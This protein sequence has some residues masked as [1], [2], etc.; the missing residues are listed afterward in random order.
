MNNDSHVKFLTFQ[1]P[2]KSHRS[3]SPVLYFNSNVKQ[4]PCWGKKK[5][6]NL[7]GYA[8]WPKIGNWVVMPLLCAEP[9]ILQFWLAW[10][11]VQSL[12]AAEHG[13]VCTISVL[14]HRSN[15]D[16]PLPPEQLVGCFGYLRWCHKPVPP[17]PCS[18]SHHTLATTSNTQLPVGSYYESIVS[19]FPYSD[20]SIIKGSSAI[21]KQ[22]PLLQN[23][24]RVGS[25]SLSDFLFWQCLNFL[26]IRWSANSKKKKVL[27]GINW[28]EMTV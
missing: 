15:I 17:S 24:I 4:P 16:R 28:K 10:K 1:C 25:M 22:C 20:W 3:I 11:E 21:K 8:K 27:G 23:V 6:P 7:H 5:C 14:K 26:L 2:W 12:S 13:L 18:L 19:V 9:L